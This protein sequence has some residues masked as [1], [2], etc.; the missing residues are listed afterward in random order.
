MFVLLAIFLLNIVAAQM[1]LPSKELASQGSNILFYF[2]NQV[3]GK[4][5][6][7]LMIVA[8]LSSTVGTT[9]TT[10]LPASRISLSMARDRVFPKVF[11]RV[12][13]SR[14]TPLIGTVIL[15]SL[16]LLGILA[17]TGDASINTA[18]SNLI[19]DIGVLIAFYYGVTG[20][21]CAWAY[22]KVAFQRVGFFF[23]GVLLPF[24]G[25]LFLLWVGYQVIKQSGS[26][27][28]WVVGAFLLGIPLV[29]VARL[30]TKGDFFKQKMITYDSI[31]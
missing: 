15:A 21:A 9:Q 2:G 3:G 18:F 23:S 30:T 28:S 17:T 12:S 16:S 8:V 29:I 11:A 1:L 14:L 7:Y 25:G 10:L 5:V 4:W 31:D 20:L 24:L 13:G 19:N 26:S 22:R 6:G 27:S